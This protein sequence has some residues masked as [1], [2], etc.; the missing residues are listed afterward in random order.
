MPTDPWAASA[1]ETT[2]RPAAGAAT[3]AGAQD[4]WWRQTWSTAWTGW[5]STA[6]SWQWVPAQPEAADTAAAG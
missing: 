1:P 4:P 2:T 5:S 6:G 3:S